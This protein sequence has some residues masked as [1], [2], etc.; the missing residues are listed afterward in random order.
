MTDKPILEIDIDES[1]FEAFRRKF[2]EYE[3]RLDR[4]P[5]AWDRAGEQQSRATARFDEMIAAMVHLSEAMARLDKEWGEERADSASTASS[6]FTLSGS[7]KNFAG[8]IWTSTLSLGKWSGLT[9]AFSALLAGGGFYGISRTAVNVS[10][11]RTSAMSYGSSY[12]EAQA[13]ETNFGRLGDASGLLAGFSNAMTSAEARAPLYTLLGPNADQKIKGKSPAAAL[14]GALPD[15]KR[16]V[17]GLDPRTMGNVL[18]ATGLDRFGLTLEKAET[19]RALPM[20]EIYRIQQGAAGDQ[21]LMNVPEDVLQNWANLNTQID[22]AGAEIETHLAGLLSALA[23]TIERLSHAA[24]GFVDH[25]LGDGSSAAKWLR[26]AGEGL[27]DFGGWISSTEFR[28]EIDSYISTTGQFINLLFSIKKTH[29]PFIVTARYTYETA[30]ALGHITAHALNRLSGLKDPWTETPTPGMG[31]RSSPVDHVAPETP[32]QAP[33]APGSAGNGQDPVSNAFSKLGEN[34]YVNRSDIQRYLAS[35]G[36]GMDPATT[37]WCAAFVGA[38]LEKA[39]IHSLKSN[40]ATSYLVWGDPVSGPIH[41]GDVL[42]ESRGLR[43]GQ[44]GGHVGL[45]T[46]DVDENGRVGMIS[47]NDGDA[48]RF[49]WE[50]PRKIVARRAHVVPPPE[51]HG[52]TNHVHVDDQTGSANVTVDT[53][54]IGPMAPGSGWRFEH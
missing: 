10:A 28:N 8:S 37:A 14:A 42:V 1:A 5:P 39:G 41:R 32:D 3:E 34:E 49:S 46:G 47:G 26:K 29:N 45:A 52:Q 12:G 15:I 30:E 2:R 13:F 53:S 38:S 17:D 54:S 51:Q 25:F 24:V 19:I 33:W 35:G 27:T 23:P 6:W 21:A 7:A 16:F 40:I 4:T 20:E 44:V 18:S 11:R 22:R 36:H 31:Y 50:D 9:A 48:V 43:P